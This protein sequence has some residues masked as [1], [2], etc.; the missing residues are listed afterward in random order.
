MRRLALFASDSDDDRRS[1]DAGVPGGDG[2][3]LSSPLSQHG[4]PVQAERQPASAAGVPPLPSSKMTATRRN[5]SQ[6]FGAAPPP[7]TSSATSGSATGRRPTAGA[8]GA[9]AMES[10]TVGGGAF[11]AP[12]FDRNDGGSGGGDAAVIAAATGDAATAL[13]TAE[14][15]VVQVYRDSLYAGTCM[16]AL[17]VPPRAAAPPSTGTAV[18]PPS[19]LPPSAAVRRHLEREQ[20]QVGASAGAVTSGPVLL[21]LSSNRQVLCRIALDAA[22]PV[23]GQ[24]TLRLRQD[25]DQPQYLT[26][27]E[28]GRAGAR[29]CWWTCM[30]PHR[31]HA[32]RFLV[33]AY[34]V[35]QCAAA[36]ATR[37]G[38]SSSSSPAPSVVRI[39]PSG[40]A[41]GAGAAGSASAASTLATVAAH[42]PATLY[43]QTW[44]LRRVN[45]QTP[46][47]VPDTCVEAVPPTAPL[48]VAPGTDGALWDAVAAAVVGMCASE[49]RLIF[50]TPE[51]THT[52]QRRADRTQRTLDAPAVV[53][54]TCERAVA[55][56]APTPA[57]PPPPPRNSAA[58]VTPVSEPATATPDTLSTGALLQQ[59]LLHSLQQQQQQVSAAAGSAGSTQQSWAGVERALEKVQVELG[60]I[61]E[62][63]DC[64]DIE[65]R[66]QR[67]NA[68][69]ERMMRRAVGLAPQAEVPI[70]DTLKDRDALLASVERYRQRYEEANTNY[71][72]ALEAMGRSSDR[73]Q[74][75]EKDL[76][77]QQELWTRQ[78]KDEA[79]HARLRLVER[80]ALHRGELERVGEER[81]AAGKSDGYADG[82]REGQ[83]AALRGLDGRGN[84]AGD[85]D[86]SGGA[87]AAVVGWRATIV[88]KDRE[89]VA[90]QTAVHDAKVRHERDR[91][92]LRAEI[93]VLSELNEKLQ[94]LQAS[95][96][97]RV[98]EDTVQQQCKRVKRTLNA[99]YSRV[100]EQLLQLASAHQRVR[101]RAQA[102]AVPPAGDAEEVEGVA[103]P[104][105]QA[106][107]DDGE[108]DTTARV[109]VDDAL[110][111][112]MQ[113]IRAE[114]QAAVAGIRAD[115]AR[116]VAANAELRA[117]TAAR[118]GGHT[119]SAA[120][121]APPRHDSGAAFVEDKRPDL[122]PPP[123]PPLP[124]VHTAA[125]QDALAALA[126][127]LLP[128]VAQVTTDAARRGE[129]ATEVDGALASSQ[130]SSTPENCGAED[131]MC[132]ARPTLASVAVV[133]ATPADPAPSAVAPRWSDLGARTPAVSDASASAGEPRSGA[134]SPS[135]SASSTSPKPSRMATRLSP[136]A[137]D[138]L[139]RRSS[140][141]LPSSDVDGR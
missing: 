60:T 78:R 84:G 27:C 9:P 62:K 132:T 66:L 5:L 40:A 80:D 104:V 46:Y 81:Y 126:A 52:P 94:H 36:L 90:L 42:V 79:E 19:L 34:A 22:E 54:V 58:V 18:A 119:P 121:P 3:G 64:L 117:L 25:A 32:S 67:N 28:G 131:G 140:S 39:P 92:Q 12:R 77:L 11:F 100:E 86:G 29:G 41:R 129:P 74:A 139:P 14:H 20:E 69:L 97:V 76:H 1:D 65:A 24:G 93:D 122:E 72:R 114:A 53:Y 4:R 31:E 2:E 107:H 56:P 123:L 26:F 35:A 43:W 98:P 6:L 38:T 130:P 88:A 99:V 125:S 37:A 138:A 63:V 73:A 91:R 45:R 124:P 15:A 101:P 16:V 8:D 17:C 137:A 82:Y 141:S 112:V 111:V 10:A 83:R 47:W 55:S 30:F 7:P 48:T 115:D 33:A 71:Q 87:A 85:G 135:P 68:E 106:D 102:S 23:V 116:R 59:L 134:A 113:T 13:I 127:S 128:G 44:T 120:S 136:P 109:C 50:V 118:R 103:A 110:A 21:L 89:I 51:D 57:P 108:V 95:A 105:G 61:R 96:D 49:A 133:G 70:E 75:L